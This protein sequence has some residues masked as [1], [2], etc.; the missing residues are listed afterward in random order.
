[1]AITHE[2]ERVS[3]NQSVITHCCEIESFIDFW[4]T[5]VAIVTLT[6]HNTTGNC[7][8]VFVYYLVEQ[9][10]MLKSYVEASCD[11]IYATAD[12]A[13]AYMF[14]RCFFLILVY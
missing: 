2:H 9:Y 13:D 8:G 5:K 14:Y 6:L 1:M 11:F 3:L 7:R 10:V 4:A 12:E